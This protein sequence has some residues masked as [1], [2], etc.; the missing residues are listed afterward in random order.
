MK[1]SSSSVYKHILTKPLYDR[2]ARKENEVPNQQVLKKSE[3]E[4]IKETLTS[5]PIDT[6]IL[7]VKGL[8]TAIRPSSAF[9]YRTRK[10]SEIE[11]LKQ[12]TE[13]V[14]ERERTEKL[15]VARIKADQAKVSALDEVK[16][17]KQLAACAQVATIRDAQIIEKKEILKSNI[18]EVKRLDL[19][20]EI[21][22]VKGLRE[23]ILTEETRRK[24]AREGRKVISD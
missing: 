2:R 9:D 19:E 16:Q 21:A 17:L 20:M 11:R 24:N 6:L 8:S 13:A 10:I 3:F 22:R 12:Q 4:R 14:D 23:E 15:E 1:S 18:E 5:P 7:Q